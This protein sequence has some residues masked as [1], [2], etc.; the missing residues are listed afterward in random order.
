M[1]NRRYKQI[2][3]VGEQMIIYHDN[4]EHPILREYFAA[5]GV[6]YMPL[7]R[8]HLLRFM[9]RKMRTHVPKK[10]V[11]CVP[12]P[13]ETDDKII[14]FD[15]HVTPP[16]LY[17]L[18]EHYPDK[19]IIF[20]YWNPADDKRIF[21]LFPRRVEIWSYSPADCEKYGFRYN[22]QFYF[23]CIAGKPA[24]T[25][26][27]CIAGNPAENEHDCAAKN[28]AE[29]GC[30]CSAGRQVGSIER[31]V[32]GT[33]RAKPTVCFIGREKGRKHNV[34]KI[35]ES[36]ERRDIATDFHFMIDGVPKNRFEEPIMPYARVIDLI[37]QSDAILD[38]TLQENAGLSLRPMEA[39]FFGKKL[40]TNQKSI[41]QYD[42]YRKEN[43]YILGEEKRGIREFLGTP[44]VEI[45]SD[46]RDHYLLSSWLR[47]FDESEEKN[48]DA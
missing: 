27:D 22:T 24:E 34:L 9:Y 47:R 17:W 16:Y 43:I 12:Q 41:R 29:N 31:E 10:M 11:F 38:Y 35:K 44:A 4:G 37:R 40:I 23:D 19:R 21:D 30:D 36:L 42:F 45:D 7:W 26:R 32:R 15:T 2:E 8:N 1:I 14:V 48:Y 18:C 39:L 5:S 20:W 28:Q 46:I 13:A 3:R 33:E 6:E 25:E